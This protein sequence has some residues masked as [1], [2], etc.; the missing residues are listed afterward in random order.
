MKSNQLNRLPDPRTAKEAVQEGAQRLDLFSDQPWRDT[1]R[2]SQRKS[3]TIL[4]NM[5]LLSRLHRSYSRGLSAL[6]IE[7]KDAWRFGFDEHDHSSGSRFGYAQLD[8]AWDAE[9]GLPLSE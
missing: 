5:C 1:A 8:A 9:L 7:S 2:S 3:N 6:K 4:P